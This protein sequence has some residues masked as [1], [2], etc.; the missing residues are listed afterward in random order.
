[1]K[2]SLL[3][4]YEIVYLHRPE[5]MRTPSGELTPDFKAIYDLYCRC[6]RLQEEQLPAEEFIDLVTRNAHFTDAEE[7][8]VGLKKNGK[9]VAA[10]NYGVY[11]GTGT[12]GIDGT[13]HDIFTMVDPESRQQGVFRALLD[14]RMAKAKSFVGKEDAHLVAFA[15]QNNPLLMTASQYMEDTKAALDQCIRRTVFEKQGYRT[16]GFRYLQPPLGSGEANTYLD[17]VVQGAPGDTLPS[18]LVKEHLSRFF[19]QS[20][21]EGTTLEHPTVSAMAND[22]S[23]RE[24]LRLERAGKF[25]K[26]GRVLNMSTMERLPEGQQDRLLGDVFPRLTQEHFRGQN[27]QKYGLHG[28]GHAQGPHVAEVRARDGATVQGRE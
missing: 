14:A 4:D 20:F 3:P 25:E 5:Q 18:A 6:F 17:L 24:Q 7:A 15:E 2:T 12:P 22:L 13:I 23:S 11:A 27:L 9:L 1:M 16:L 19:A 28:Q 8:W 26:L 21:L 10:A